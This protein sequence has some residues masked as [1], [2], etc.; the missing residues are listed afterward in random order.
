VRPFDAIIIGSGFGGVM[1]AYELVQAGLRVLML[2]RGSWVGRG[3]HNWGPHGSVDLTPHYSLETPYRLE[4]GGPSRTI[5]A[6]SCVGGPSVFFGGVTLRL[7]EA[8]FESPA[9]IVG[10]SGAEWPIQY[11]DLEPYYARAERL[12]GVAGVAGDDPTEPPRSGPYPHP[13]APLTET[14]RL[15]ERVGREMGL[16]PYR[17][18]LAIHHTPGTRTPCI[19]CT[20]CDTFAC[21]I[22][23][24]NDL[25]TVMIPDLI[26]R[27][28]VLMP[29][30]VA[31]R[32]EVR[33]RKVTG[34]E[35]VNRSSGGRVTWRAPRIVL[36]AGA[37]GTPHLLM[38]SDLQRLNPAG[39]AIGRHLLRHANG[40]TYGYLRD[41]PDRGLRFHKQLGFNDYYF[42]DPDA[43]EVRGK[44]GCIQQLQAPPPALVRQNVR[45]PI[46]PLAGLLALT[47]PHVTG[48]LVMAEDQPRSENRVTL[49]R[50]RSDR[51][52]LPQMVIHHHH[53]S[54][55][56]AA[57]RALL[58]RTR[59]LLRAVGARAF[60]THHIETFSHAAGTVRFG[61]DP[62]TAPLDP[63]CRFR[64]IEDLYVVD[65]S[66][67]PT[68]GGVNP[69]LT[70]AANALR[71]GEA[72][73]KNH[74]P[75][76]EESSCRTPHLDRSTSR[77]SA[78]A[79]PLS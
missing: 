30:T 74:L 37:L 70:I 78:V 36:A 46:K 47:F 68:G 32:L 45:F 35:C 67:M 25:A 2:E 55:D 3:L 73:A 65:A 8:D 56:Q 27:G 75:R 76:I 49:D 39:D 54:R 69:S 5:G 18:P 14:P 43:R 77:S 20:S 21:A 44:L 57:R 41:L 66:F 22:S 23:A 31:V 34:V 6:Y 53:T 52:G 33:G 29:D 61:L 7:R 16:H 26:A 48:L 15:L 71:V 58:R 79:S 11:S 51:Y 40:M 38:A 59:G 42:G 50:S 28:M 19:G 9:E 4:N 64:G 17:L 12:L 63:W 72:I 1:A 13:P 60:W 24:K 62:R 10:D